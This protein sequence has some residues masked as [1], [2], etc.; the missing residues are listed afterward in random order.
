MTAPAA[1]GTYELRYWSA[2][3][4]EVLAVQPI[5]VAAAT[6]SLTAPA[7]I[8]GGTTF[9][10]AWTG[11]ADTGDRL[12]IVDADG[13]AVMPPIRVSLFGR[14]NLM[15]APIDAGT[16]ELVYLVGTEGDA[17]ARQAITVT[18]ITAAVT[19]PTQAAPDAAIEVEWQGPAGRFDEI[20]LVDGEGAIRSAT[21]TIDSP[22]VLTAP[23]E[24]ATY[25]V[26]YWAGGADRVLATAEIVVTCA[27][28][29]PIEPDAPLRLG[30]A[31]AAPG[32]E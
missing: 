22:A 10:V 32:A 15:D 11:D 4:G 2:A 23:A 8:E 5:E 31:P 1:P 16:Y 20:R 12:A 18:A 14:P 26:Q 9:E 17:I 28:C 19:A 13:E 6:A 24:P 29:P 3:V 7:E 21:R 27:G 30:P 25:V